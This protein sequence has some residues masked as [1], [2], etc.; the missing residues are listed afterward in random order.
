MT[1]KEAQQRGAVRY[2]GQPCRRGHNGE[3]Y[4]K[5]AACVHC[6]ALKRGITLDRRN[7]SN[8]N[9]ALANAARSEGRLTYIPAT[10]C[11]HG[12]S[13]RWVDS[14]N[15]V[16]CDAAQREKWKD[17]KRFARL[18]KEYG[19]SKERYFKLVDAQASCCKLCGVHSA[20]PF[21]LHVDHCHE[22]GRVRGLLCGKCNQGIGLL[23]H[24]P[25]L[26]KK[27]ALYCQ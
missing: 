21:A 19:L 1:R 27:A 6:V 13:E 15:C 26:L 23:G 3:R 4:T 2:A 7:R 16:A 5:G 20:N 24:S 17:A 14:N 12:H 8:R 25:E 18:L 9:D 10:P 11:R 22:S